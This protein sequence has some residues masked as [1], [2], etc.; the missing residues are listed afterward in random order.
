MG[1]IE[2]KLFGT[3]TVVL[4]N[5][6]TVTELGGIKPRQIL[7]ILA[8]SVGTPISKD[9]LV[10]QL[11]GDHPP[12]TYNATLESYISMLRRRMGGSRGR[13]SPLATT[14]TGYLLDPAQ[15]RVDVEDFR[16]L[17]Q[18][19]PG[20]TPELALVRTEQALRLVTGELLASEPYA[21]WAADERGH[22]QTEYLHAC[23][24][25]AAHALAI[26]RPHVAV[27]MARAAVGVDAMSETSWQ[28]LIR[29]LAATG[30]RSE[31]L[32]AYLDLRRTLVDALGTEPSAV[33][34][35]LYLGLLAEDRRPSS[36]ATSVHEVR[37]LLDLLRDALDGLPES[38]LSPRDRRVTERAERLVRA[39]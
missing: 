16:Q 11:W 28:L 4:S 39:A 32:R 21:E 8:S 10:E 19:D 31:A 9:R 14:S 34:R 27:E 13:R 26:S 2:V 7:E 3:T 18:P 6:S 29:G 1:K 20:V 30:A 25:A 33:S 36:P 35:E 37:T 38:D 15:V 12:R 17:V 5:G 22:F 24:Q 23:N